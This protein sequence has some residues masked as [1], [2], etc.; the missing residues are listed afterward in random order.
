MMTKK[1]TLILV[2]LVGIIIDATA[3]LGVSGAYFANI[4]HQH[5][6][7]KDNHSIK[8]GSSL[9]YY[10]GADYSFNVL[11]VG[12]G[13]T[14]LN[15]EDELYTNAVPAFVSTQN[16]YFSVPVAITTTP[17]NRR[18][19]RYNYRRQLTSNI[20]LT[21]IPSF[22]QKTAAIIN[23]GSTTENS[24]LL[25]N[26]YAKFQHAL[27]LSM[28]FKAQIT[29]GIHLSLEPFVGVHNSYLKAYDNKAVDGINLGINFRLVAN[30]DIDFNIRKVIVSGSST[31][32]KDL[33]EKQKEIENQL[34]NKPKN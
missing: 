31:S 24:E 26:R 33:L 6:V 8:S 25:A 11:S 10:Y 7:I 1:T 34:K 17:Y 28:L 29:S 23:H 20:K 2:F 16:R 9:G 13:M 3:Q 14:S 4:N 21:Y 18:F 30:I 32:K 19:S 5:A 12:V 15:F 27:R 22:K